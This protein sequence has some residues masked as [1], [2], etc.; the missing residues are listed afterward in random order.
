MNYIYNQEAV[1]NL[2]TFQYVSINIE[3]YTDR[4]PDESHLHSNMSLLI[5]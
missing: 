4:T 1:E 2:F 5:F 3:L